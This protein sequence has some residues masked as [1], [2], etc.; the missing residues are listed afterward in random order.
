[1]NLYTCVLVENQFVTLERAAHELS[2]HTRTIRRWIQDGKLPATRIGRKYLIPIK[3]F[4][5]LLPPETPLQASLKPQAS[6]LPEQGLPLRSQFVTLER[7]AQDFNVHVGT[8]RRWVREGTLPATKVGRRYLI[9]SKAIEGLKAPGAPQHMTPGPQ[10]ISDAQQ[11]V[12]LLPLW[13][14]FSPI[15]YRH[16]YLVANTCSLTAAET[17]TRGIELV[18]K[19]HHGQPK[20]P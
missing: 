12:D 9:P 19:E 1:M 7:A 4:E 2:V 5:G 16:L 15:W 17:L 14:Q 3:V 20:S 11:T 8:V 13:L 6:A 10:T 18:L